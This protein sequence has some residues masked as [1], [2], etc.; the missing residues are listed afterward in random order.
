MFSIIF[1]RL[2]FFNFWEV[3]ALRVFNLFSFL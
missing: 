3:I 2:E 1:V